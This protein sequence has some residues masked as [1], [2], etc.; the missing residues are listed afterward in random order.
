MNTEGT[1]AAKK[2]NT[3]PLT[4]A[5]LPVGPKV[6]WVAMYIGLESYSAT[7]GRSLHLSDLISCS[8]QDGHGHSCSDSTLGRVMSTLSR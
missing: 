1:V 8:I 2:R 6:G 3:L 5:D 7:R 4:G